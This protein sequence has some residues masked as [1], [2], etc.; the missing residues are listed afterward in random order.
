MTRA[1]VDRDIASAPSFSARRSA[2]RERPNWSAGDRCPMASLNAILDFAYAV[3][4]GQ[5]QIKLVATKQRVSI[6]LDDPFWQLSKEKLIEACGS[7]SEPGGPGS[8][9]R[10]GAA[11]A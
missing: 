11:V 7:G 3:L 6:G 8:D 4:Q 1:C 2:V 5:M 10:R 9:R